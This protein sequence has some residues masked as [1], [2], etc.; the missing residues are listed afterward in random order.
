MPA[1]KSDIKIMVEANG[2]RFSIN[3]RRHLFNKYS[4]KL[5]RSKSIKNGLLTIT[6]IT[7]LTRK[8]LV[9]QEIKK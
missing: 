4:I 2:N 7:E 8:W 6:E 9:K 5:G 1:R 3:C